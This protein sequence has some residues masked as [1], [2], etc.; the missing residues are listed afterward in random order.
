MRALL[1]RAV[2]R[3]LAKP[4]I[5]DWLIHKALKTPYTHIWKEGKPYMQRYWL[6]NPYP[7][8]D[9]GG[10]RR[11]GD[12]LPSVRVHWIRLEDQDEHPHDHPW[13]ARTIVLR[14]WYREERL[15]CERIDKPDFTFDMQDVA[16]TCLRK[17]GDTAPV[18]FGQY[19]KITA[20]SPGGV[21]T[22]FITWKYRG[23]WGFLVDGVKMPYKQYLN[24]GRRAADKETS[25]G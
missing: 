5:A 1:W 25:N 16:R 6:F 10:R 12:W 20:I 17:E 23:V 4:S 2:A 9:N 11:W 24:R 3:T 18:L 7:G 15:E 13:D 21:W 22:L 19:H 8:P 14:N